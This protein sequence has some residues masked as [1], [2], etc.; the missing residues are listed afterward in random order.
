MGASVAQ[1]KNSWSNVLISIIDQ[2]LELGLPLCKEKLG[3]YKYMLFLGHC[4]LI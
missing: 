4:V 2:I 3:R 1:D